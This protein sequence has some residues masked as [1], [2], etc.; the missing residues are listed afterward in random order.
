M[1]INDLRHRNLEIWRRSIV[2][3][4]TVYK[5]IEGFPSYEKYVLSDQMRRAVIS[6]PSNIAEGSKRKTVKDFKNYLSIASGSLA[7]LDTQLVVA[8][9]LDYIEYSRELQEEVVA[10]M[11]MIGS[12]SASLHD[13]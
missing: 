8:H 7:E 3:V 10:L 11:K 4:K 6:I 1:S 12:F 13:F 5:V 9:E 2:L